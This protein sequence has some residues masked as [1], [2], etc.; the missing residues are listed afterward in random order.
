MIKRILILIITLAFS[1]SI[2]SED[3]SDILVLSD[4]A[5]VPDYVKEVITINL[6][7]Q[8]PPDMRMR[9]AFWFALNDFK[10]FTAER[11]T[12]IRQVLIGPAVDLLILFYEDTVKAIETKKP[13]K[14]EQRTSLE[15]ELLPL[16]A[17]TVATI[18]QHTKLQES[19]LS[20]AENEK[21]AGETIK[22]VHGFLDILY[23]SKKNLD[24]LF[25]PIPLN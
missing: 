16:N 2:Y 13:F 7:S 5:E 18:S 12:V 21:L 15:N 24:L 4:Q 9:R 20:R 11:T 22:L 8:Y 25:I 14:S 10:P 1:L 3:V 23:N 19:I 17:I 6:R